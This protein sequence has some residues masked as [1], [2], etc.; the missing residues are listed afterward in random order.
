V[1]VSGSFYLCARFW[2]TAQKVVQLKAGT[3]RK[4]R[5]GLQKKLKK[6]FKKFGSVK[7]MYV[8][9]QPQTKRRQNN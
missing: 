9:L 6:V 5:S 8:P 2:K 3:G 4:R 1:D 7:V